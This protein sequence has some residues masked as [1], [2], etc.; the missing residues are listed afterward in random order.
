M[1]ERG[2]EPG[3][4]DSRPLP[5]TMVLRCFHKPYCIPAPPFLGVSVSCGQTLKDGRSENVGLRSPADGMYSMVAIVNSTVL[6]IG[7]LL[8]EWIE[9]DLITHTH[10]RL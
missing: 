7:K 10:T 9:K 5:L 2:C 3:L 4:S 6:C 1:V 8:R